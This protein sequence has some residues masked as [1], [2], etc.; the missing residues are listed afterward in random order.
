VLRAAAPAAADCAA[1]FLCC[2]GRRGGDLLQKLAN[3]D[4]AKPAVD[5]EGQ[6]LVDGLLALLLG[7]QVGRVFPWLRC[8][9]WCLWTCLG[10]VS[11]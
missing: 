10:S 11:S 2:F 8:V 5:L 9:R 7:D 1:A 4:A 6:S 3:P